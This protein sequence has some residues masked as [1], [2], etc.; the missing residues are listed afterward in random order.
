MVAFLQVIKRHFK[1]EGGEA[2]WLEGRTYL[3]IVSE[4]NV[5]PR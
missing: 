2:G 4:P 1:L 5:L 3:E